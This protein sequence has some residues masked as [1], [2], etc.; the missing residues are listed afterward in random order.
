MGRSPSGARPVVKFGSA[1]LADWAGCAAGGVGLLGWWGCWGEARLLLGR[2]SLDGRWGRKI[3]ELGLFVS[4]VDRVWV[5]LV[6]AA[7]TS[8]LPAWEGLAAISR[9]HRFQRSLGCSRCGAPACGGEGNLVSSLEESGFAAAAA[10]RPEA[11]R[12]RSSLS[13][14]A[15][16]KGL[17]VLPRQHAG[18]KV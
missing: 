12:L 14:S 13:A 10:S 11:C 16:Q 5:A 2:A 8:R 7:G 15:A 6:A 1:S 17:G 4:F 3:E 9:A 18:S